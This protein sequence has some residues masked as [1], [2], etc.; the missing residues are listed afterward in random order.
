MRRLLT[1]P[2]IAAIH[3]TS[4]LGA[5][6]R[7]GSGTSV[8]RIVPAPAA[9]AN[10]DI[11]SVKTQ[12]EQPCR[13]SFLHPHRLSAG[14][15]TFGTYRT[16]RRANVYTEP[17]TLSRIVRSLERGGSVTVGGSRCGWAPVLEGRGGWVHVGFI[18]YSLD[19]VQHS[20]ARQ[21]PVSRTNADGGTTPMAT[22]PAAVPARP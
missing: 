12:T 16:P 4:S 15:V 11:R 17:D 9:H 7:L 13:H 20:T 19:D 5:Q 6:V 8:P 2:L 18:E 21:E 22:A 14:P 1:I 3:A 10:H